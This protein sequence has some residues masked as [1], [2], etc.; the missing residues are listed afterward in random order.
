MKILFID[1]NGN[2]SWHCTQAAIDRGHEVWQLN[3][4]QSILTRRRV[5]PEV[6]KVK[7]DMRETEQIKV[8]MEHAFFDVVCDFICFNAEQ[9]RTDIDIF[10]GKTS[11]FF[12]ISSDSVYKNSSSIDD[13]YTEDSSLYSI[14]TCDCEYIVGK[15]KAEHVFMQ[16]FAGDGFPITIV[17]PAY[18][19]DTIFPISI[20]HNCFT[21]EE[22]I[23]KGYPLLIAGD[24]N[25]LWPFTHSSDFAAAFIGLVENYDTVGECFHIGSDEL[26][27]WNE[28][29]ETV[30]HALHAEQSGI[31]HVPAQDALS[32]NDIQ[33][34]E[35]MVQ[36]M[37]PHILS[38]AKVKKY[39]RNCGARTHVEKGMQQT[40]R[41]LNENPVH[42]RHVERIEIALM[43]IYHK[44]NLD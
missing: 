23:L 38:T 17:R 5:Q 10:L 24:G 8:L 6:H 29:S 13:P 3:R 25:N 39:V 19:Y 20:G 22:L 43:D 28:Q 11:H 31:F 33:P 36:R 44:Y 7:G 9:A 18:T 21:A 12:F 42:R 34:R 37:R 16:A 27:T 15:L 41:W 30:L 2:I 1:G 26:L 4:E 32:F 40:T 14:E 35:M